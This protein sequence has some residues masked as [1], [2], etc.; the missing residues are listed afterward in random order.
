[1][2]G[3]D[4]DLQVVYKHD[5]TLTLAPIGQWINGLMSASSSSIQHVDAATE[6]LPVSNSDFRMYSTDN[7]GFISYQQV[8][9]VRRVTLSALTTPQILKISMATGR[10]R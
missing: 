9:G 5:E 7:S 3:L 1:M 8:L 4:K 6:Y 2:P 10:S